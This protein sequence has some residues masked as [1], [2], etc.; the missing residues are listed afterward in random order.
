MKVPSLR[1]AI[2]VNVSIL[3]DLEGELSKRLS[4]F[5]N[6]VATGE[7]GVLTIIGGYG[8]GKTHVLKHLKYRVEQRGF[9]SIYVV[10]TGRSFMD[11][12][13]SVLENIL[14]VLLNNVEDVKN[15]VLKH[16]LDLYSKLEEGL[17]VYVKSW[18]LGYSVP[19]TIR[20]KLGLVGTVKDHIAVRFL[21]ESLQIIARRLGAIFV[22]LDEVETLLNLPKSARI[23]Y[24][25]HL[26]ELIDHIPRGVGFAL[27]MTPACWDELS[28]INPALARRLSGG[29]LYLKPLK[30]EHLRGFINL[31]FAELSNILEE[32]SLDLIYEAANGVYGEVLKYVSILLEEA[33]TNGMKHVN[34]EEAKRILA[35][36]L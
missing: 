7:R 14:D 11:L 8:M 22:L 10:S 19:P 9:R 28:S 25:E 34:A 27:S 29:L 35:D 12:Y 33:I 24:A 1:L 20:Y 23:A 13:S 16:A 2:P 30:R 3:Y 26:R 5:L 6:T 21:C 32:D 15:A 4:V 31:Y 18:L 17:A 36:Y